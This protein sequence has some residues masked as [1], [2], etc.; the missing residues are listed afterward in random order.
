MQDPQPDRGSPTR[1]SDLVP[2]R[3]CGECVACCVLPSINTEAFQKPANTMCMHCSGKGCEIYTARPDVCRSFYCLW[4]K[5]GLMGD[6]HR[7]DRLGVMF[8]VVRATSPVNILRQLYVVGL[9]L[10]Q[11][12]NYAT[13]EVKAALAILQRR[14]VPVWLYFGDVLKCVH[15]G[16]AVQDVLLNGR[17]ASNEAHATEVS[18]WR[19]ALA[20][21]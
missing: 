19:A 14:R 15:P 18:A 7:P 3:E 11:F 13:P 16:S 10:K 20:A 1:Q 21:R 12:P 6:A 17:T 4:R 8:H 2:D 9:P 5:L